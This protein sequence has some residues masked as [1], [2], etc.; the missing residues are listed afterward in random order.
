MES[1]SKI[2]MSRQRP[3]PA[4]D[5]I[6]TGSGAEIRCACS[7]S[8]STSESHTSTQID[9]REHTRCSMS[10]PSICF[11]KSGLK[12]FFWRSSRK[13]LT[14]STCPFENFKTKKQN[15]CRCYSHI[16]RKSR[17]QPKPNNNKCERLLHF[18]WGKSVREHCFYTLIW[19]SHQ[20]Q[21]REQKTT[22]SF[23][24]EFWI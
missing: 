20:I 8:Y 15:D 7:K 14:I 21:D 2:L 6:P 19:V 12:S 18:T 13:N 4:I 11:L 22:L 23:Q 17:K 24:E 1:I 3:N 10:R 5:I 16:I 9:K